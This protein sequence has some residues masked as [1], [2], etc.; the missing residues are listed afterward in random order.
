MLIKKNKP[1][2]T[3]DT[4]TYWAGVDTPPALLWVSCTAT[5]HVSVTEICADG[6]RIATHR[7]LYSLH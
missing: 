3:E 7:L 6:K 4:A 2:E 1:V 5:S